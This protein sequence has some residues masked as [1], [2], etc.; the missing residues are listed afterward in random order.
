MKSFSL[1]DSKHT[2]PKTGSHSKASTM[3]NMEKEHER[4][5]HSEDMNGERD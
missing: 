3:E 2:S 4:C 1:S 5:S